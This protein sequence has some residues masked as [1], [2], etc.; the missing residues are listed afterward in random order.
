M[1][2]LY[3]LLG[4]LAGAAAVTI[5]H[6]LIRK[7]YSGAP[8]LDKLGEEAAAKLINA[9]GNKAPNEEDLYV[10]TL[11]ADIIS[12]AFYFGLATVRAKN[13][14]MAGLTAG[15]A[16]GIGAIKLPAKLGLDPEYTAGTN[17]KKGITIGLYTLGGI[18]A[19][20]IVRALKGREKA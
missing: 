10:P 12:N 17:E 16:A 20:V 19:G 11:T 15:A 18:L 13:P 6:E 1:R 14:L 8:R 7:N 5:A 3:A 9:T 2:I 4:G